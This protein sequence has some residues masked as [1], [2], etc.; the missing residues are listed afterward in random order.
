MKE[1]KRQY[2]GIYA[3]AYYDRTGISRHLEKM[4]ARGWML[5]HIGS[6]AWHY[7]REEPK[8]LRFSV[9]YFPAA[10]QFDPEPT[11]ELATFRDYCA[12]AGWQLA[13]D[14]AQMQIF[15]NEQEDPV[16]IET[17]PAVELKNLRR[18][19]RR[20]F[21]PAYGFLLL[22]ALLLCGTQFRQFRNAPL[23]VLT[24]DLS[25][26]NLFD[27][28]PLLLLSSAELLLYALWLRRAKPAAETGMPLPELHTPRWLKRLTWGIVVLQLFV[29]LCSSL[30]VSKQMLLL[31]LAILAY[32]GVMLLLVHTASSAMRHLR[33]RAWVNRLV[34]VGMILALT[35]G[36]FAGMIAWIFHSDGRLD[37]SQPAEAYEYM[38]WTWQIYHDDIPLR[39]EDLIE[40]DYDRWSTE[41]R[42]EGSVLLSRTEYSQQA[43]VE[44]KDE[45]EL[46][47]TVIRVKIPALYDFVEQAL[48]RQAERFN[49]PDLPE[50]WSTYQSVDPTSWGIPRVYQR[51]RD[52]SPTNRYLLCFEDRF[53]EV[54][55][56]HAW[57][58]TEAQMSIT[59]EALKNA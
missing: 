11:E 4:A 25:L 18:S 48:R 28:L 55:F 27:W 16:P 35:V 12:A 41:A 53:A 24:S 26:M 17:D 58:V 10:S 36:M 3:N 32:M 22:E 23:D 7:R 33:F 57:T 1:R 44:D 50:F 46:T 52:H 14:T 56:D 43:R 38:G 34:S 40:T 42:R 15:Y 29:L 5:D 31:L 51:F 8:K 13:A 20:S 9:V 21:L 6:G 59:A 19:L 37:G 47:Y 39:L 49:D 45:P 30:R 2:M 54:T